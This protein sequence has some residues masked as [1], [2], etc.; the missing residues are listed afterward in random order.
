M[1][2]DAPL[3]DWTPPQPLGAT[4]DADRDANRL[5]AQAKRVYAIMKDGKEHTLSELSSA[6]GDPE[7][8]VSARLRDIRRSGKTIDRRYVSNGLWAY[9][10]VG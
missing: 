7:A 6:T 1:S 3:L 2:G 8:S 4:L 5:T 10:M 9:R